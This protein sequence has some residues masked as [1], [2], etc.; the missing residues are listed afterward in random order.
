MKTKDKHT[1]TD[2][3]K[4]IS[5]DQKKQTEN[6]A[7]LSD[8]IEDWASPEFNT[9][10]NEELAEKIKDNPNKFIGCGS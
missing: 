4:P 10:L 8:Q 6:K 9:S 2:K 7:S 5:T 3:V 1:S